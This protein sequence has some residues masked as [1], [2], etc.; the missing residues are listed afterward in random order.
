MLW[1]LVPGVTAV[2]ALAVM[3]FLLWRA[4][5]RL[6]IIDVR[7]IAQERDSA[8]KKAIILERAERLLSSLFRRLK[9]KIVPAFKLLRRHFHSWYERAVE[10]EKRYRRLG[11]S[12]ESARPPVGQ[13]LLSEGSAL[14]AQGKTKEAEQKFIEAISLNPK[15]TRAYEELGRL[16]VRLGQWKEAS[17]AFDFLLRLNPEDASVHANLGE[18]EMAKGDVSSAIGH[19]EQ[20]VA[21]KPANPQL[22]SLLLDA[23]IAVRRKD[24]VLRVFARL[25]EVSP[26]YPRLADFEERIRRM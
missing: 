22:I 9:K 3:L 12:A 5:P 26:Q 13:S 7:T 4:L 8:R 14:A 6:V 15:D 24:L 11:S 20:A 23:A 25:K 21:L 17:E 16:Y 10:L 1:I 2:L 19:F 18:M